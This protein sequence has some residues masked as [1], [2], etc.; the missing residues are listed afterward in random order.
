MEQPIEPIAYF[1]GEFC[2]K[3]VISKSSFYREVNARRLRIYKRGKRT[4]IERAEAE[5]WYAS[6]THHLM[7]MPENGGGSR[8]SAY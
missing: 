7:Q 8:P 2:E 4:M 3:F 6:L 1:I 5:R